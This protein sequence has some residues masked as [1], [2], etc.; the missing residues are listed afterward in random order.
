MSLKVLIA[1]Q[2]PLV[3]STAQSK[4]AMTYAECKEYSNYYFEGYCYSYC[5]SAT[6]YSPDDANTCLACPSE[7]NECTVNATTKVPYCQSCAN[8]FET[9]L[10]GGC[11]EVFDL[12][13]KPVIAIIILLSVLLTLRVV[14]EIILWNKARRESL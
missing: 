5:P 14:V 10:S 1:L 2:L 13:I 11:L 4:Q 8:G 12:V 9:T 7:C 3:L 6:Y